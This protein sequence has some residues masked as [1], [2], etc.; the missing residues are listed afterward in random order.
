MINTAAAYI[1]VLIFNGGFGAG[2]LAIHE[3]SNYESCKAAITQ[4]EPVR[5]LQGYCVAKEVK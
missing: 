3:F 5:E 1:L 4:L 2:G